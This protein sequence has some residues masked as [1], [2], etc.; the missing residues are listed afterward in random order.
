MWNDAPLI[1]WTGRDLQPAELLKEILHPP[2]DVAV[3]NEKYILFS[4]CIHLLYKYGNL[5]GF[6]NLPVLGRRAGRR[7]LRVYETRHNCRGHWERMCWHIC[8]LQWKWNLMLHAIYFL[9]STIWNRFL[10]SEILTW[11]IKIDDVFILT[12]WYWSQFQ[13]GY[14]IMFLCKIM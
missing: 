1:R 2:F 3:M 13:W 6:G 9:N 7:L 10:G 8:H 5:W 14:E 12:E 11:I 4:E